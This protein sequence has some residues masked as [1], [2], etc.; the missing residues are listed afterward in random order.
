MSTHVCTCTGVLPGVLMDVLL[1]VLPVVWLCALL[2]VLL[3]DKM[4]PGEPE[5]SE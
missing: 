1:D 4:T 2:G 5:D 3:W